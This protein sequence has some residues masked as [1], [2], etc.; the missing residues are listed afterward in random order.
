MF[1]YTELNKA[2]HHCQKFGWLD[3]DHNTA[4]MACVM[5]NCWKLLYD[6]QNKALV[7]QQF[8]DSDCTHKNT[9]D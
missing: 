6:A 5:L 8:D 1:Q 2:G 7:V 3:I 9:L 4:A